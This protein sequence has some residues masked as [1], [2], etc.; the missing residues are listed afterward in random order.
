MRLDRVVD[1]DGA[2]CALPL[3]RPAEITGRET[4]L[5]VRSLPRATSASD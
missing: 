4:W 1:G 3:T 2:A 5:A